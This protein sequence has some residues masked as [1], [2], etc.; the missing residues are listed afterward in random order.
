MMLD[1]ARRPRAPLPC[2][3]CVSFNTVTIDVRPD[4][5]MLDELTQSDPALAAELRAAGMASAIWRVRTCR[6]CGAAVYS[7]E[8]AVDGR[9]VRRR[10][11]QLRAWRAGAHVAGWRAGGPVLSSAAD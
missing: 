1:P 8:I 7:A 6:D 4:P 11:S 2:R 5:D 9:L 10:L 3:R